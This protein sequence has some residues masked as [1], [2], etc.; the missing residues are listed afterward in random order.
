M[1]LQACDI[2]M[3]ITLLPMGSADIMS[4]LRPQHLKDVPAIPALLNIIMGGQVLNSVRPF[5]AGANL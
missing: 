5:S 3:P 4:G 1:F 2:R